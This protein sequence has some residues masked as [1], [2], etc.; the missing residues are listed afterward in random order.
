MQSHVSVVDADGGITHLLL[1]GARMTLP[2][3]RRGI[4][5]GLAAGVPLLL[6]ALVELARRSLVRTSGKGPELLGHRQV[7]ESRIGPVHVRHVPGSDAWSLVLVHG[8]SGCAD[9]TW[10]AVIPHLAGGPSIYAIDLPGHG[11]APLGTGF[12]LEDAAR[13][14]AAVVDQAAE[15][16]PVALVG[17]SMGGAASL[18]GF[19]M[20]IMGSVDRYVAVATADRFAVPSL[21][22][23]LW[24]ARIF[25]AGD[26]SPFIL[27]ETWRRSRVSKEEMVAWIFRN[28]PSRTVL[29]QSAVALMRFDLSDTDLRL[30][31]GSEWIVAG[32]D[33]VIPVAE[34]IESAR[35]HGLPITEL[36]ASHAITLEHPADLA[37]LIMSQRKTTPGPGATS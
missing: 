11:E 28:R 5:V 27:Q 35:R 26:R 3:S 18:T 17:F 13:R 15:T 23:K 4:G 2:L 8:W 24:A 20:G 32:A 30:P 21:T 9:V 1:R 14:I 36:D 37:R 16:G 31:D 25:G 7:L 10:H 19:S 34:Q 22:M 29:N 12:R 33:T 6:G